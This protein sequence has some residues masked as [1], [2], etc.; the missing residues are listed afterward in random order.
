MKIL[1]RIWLAVLL[2][3]LCLNNAE[4]AIA[5]TNLITAKITVI[6][7]ISNGF[8]ITVNSSTRTVT[9]NV[10][11]AAT[12]ILTNHTITGATSNLN[13]HIAA[14]AFAGVKMSG[15]TN[16]S[17]VLYLRGVLGGALGVT[18]LSNWATVVYST[19][20][21]SSGMIDVRVPYQA[22]AASVQTNIVNGIVGILNDPN[23]NDKI[24][25]NAP[26]FSNFID[27]SGRPQRLENDVIVNATLE[28]GTSTN[29]VITNAVR[30]NAGTISTPVGAIGDLTSLSLSNSANALFGGVS[31][32]G[33]EVF[34]NDTIEMQNLGLIAR[35]G[36]IIQLSGGYSLLGRVHAQA[37]ISNSLFYYG[38]GPFTNLGYAYLM[39]GFYAASPSE[40]GDNVFFNGADITHSAGNTASFGRTTLANLTVH[41]GIL[42]AGSNTWSGDI[43]FVPKSNAGLANGANSGVILGSNVL[44]QLSGPTAAYTIAG[45]GAERSGSFHIV[46]MDNPVSSVSIL[47]NSGTEAVAANRILMGG[48]ST[49]GTAL[50]LTNNPAWIQTVYDSTASRH[51]VIS[52][53]R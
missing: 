8:A 48:V 15:Y 19:Q 17:N 12:Q 33:A 7:A 22:E 23:V 3:L 39:S 25:T 51:R 29:Q 4:A 28:G 42:I 21:F 11:A 26:A 32:F 20:V 24:N 38:V 36:N 18:I 13:S 43:A 1:L 14:A 45:F 49:A 2:A 37:G 6:T 10:T 30:V 44:V 41:G 53:S 40:F 9:N 35:L 34:F 16:G 31:Y 27:T 46:Q 52:H 5:T 50:V 47:E